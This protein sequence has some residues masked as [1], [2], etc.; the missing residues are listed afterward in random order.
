MQLLRVTSGKYTKKLI[1]HEQKKA[2][3]RNHMLITGVRKSTPE[4]RGMTWD[5]SFELH[6]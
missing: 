1:G 4:I 3:M 6:E 5:I 2:N